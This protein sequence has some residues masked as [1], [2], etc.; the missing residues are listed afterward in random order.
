MFD[1]KYLQKIHVLSRDGHIGFFLF[2]SFCLEASTAF[3]CKKFSW[4]FHAE[5]SKVTEA[6]VIIITLWEVQGGYRYPY[7]YTA[8]YGAHEKPVE[9]RYSRRKEAEAGG[10]A[11]TT[12]VTFEP[13]PDFGRSQS[14]LPPEPDCAKR[15]TL[16]KI[17]GGSSRGQEGALSEAQGG[18]GNG[19]GEW[20]GWQGGVGRR[21][22][23]EAIFPRLHA[24][25]GKH[26][27]VR[28]SATA[29]LVAD[30]HAEERLRRSFRLL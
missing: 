24:G 7:D 3:S 16:D 5:N 28:Q 13:P 6:Q 22:A 20:Q 9:Y 8:E 26:P 23:R 12:V 27:S 18:L 17:F 2:S 21:P 30:W 4:L 14:I 1:E 15:P 10:G 29:W 19:S 11:D 25:G